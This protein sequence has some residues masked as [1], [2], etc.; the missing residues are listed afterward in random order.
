M[1]TIKGANGIKTYQM[2]GNQLLPDIYEQSTHFNIT[3]PAILQKL[4]GK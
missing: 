4:I 2:Q 1:M 3:D